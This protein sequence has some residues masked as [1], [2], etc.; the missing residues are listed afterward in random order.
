M[1]FAPAGLTKYT[2]PDSVTSIING[3]IEAPSLIEIT[4]PD[5]VTSIED[6][7][8]PCNS[9]TSIYCKA[10][11]PPTISYSTFYSVAPDFKIYVPMESVEAYKSAEYW[12]N[13]ADAIVGYNF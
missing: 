4:I 7:A 11:I 1:A 10:V 5:S 12:S 13:H 2:I 8:F 3:A 9:L 6:S